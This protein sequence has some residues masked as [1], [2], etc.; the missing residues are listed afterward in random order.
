MQRCQ[1]SYRK[2]IEL[3]HGIYKKGINPKDQRQIKDFLTN[4]L[5]EEEVF[6]NSITKALAVKRQDAIDVMT[7]LSQLQ[8]P[9]HIDTFSAILTL[10]QEDENYKDNVKK[11]IK[12]LTQTLSI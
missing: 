9:I 6:K 4:F 12:E 11:V 5:F 2:G 3:I 7:A 8:G 1:N 10:Q